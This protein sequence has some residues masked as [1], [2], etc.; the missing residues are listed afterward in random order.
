MKE[1]PGGAKELSPF[2]I[3]AGWVAIGL[4]ATFSSSQSI[5]L[6]K[7]EDLILVLSIT[8]LDYVCK[9]STSI[10]QAQELAS[11][12]QDHPFKSNILLDSRLVP[13]FKYL[14]AELQ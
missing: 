10:L 4:A 7:G 5:I 11:D 8:P 2:L 12:L 14:K 1:R 13:T 9:R 6:W 3:W